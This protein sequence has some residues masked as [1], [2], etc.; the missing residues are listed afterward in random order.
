M[1]IAYFMEN[2]KFLQYFFEFLRAPTVKL[3]YYLKNTI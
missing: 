2:Q 1:R 3:L